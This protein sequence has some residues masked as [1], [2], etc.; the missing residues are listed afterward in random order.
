MP[1]LHALEREGCNE[2]QLSPKCNRLSV[3]S[4]IKGEND[5]KFASFALAD[6]DAIMLIF[7]SYK[8]RNQKIR[9]VMKPFRIASEAAIKWQEGP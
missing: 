1:L 4:E 9:H 5:K 2:S 3:I 6:S 7:Q 8:K